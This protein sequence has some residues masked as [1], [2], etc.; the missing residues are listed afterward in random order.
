ML[1]WRREARTRFYTSVLP[2][3]IV[4]AQPDVNFDQPIVSE[5]Q[6]REM[7]LEAMRDFERDQD[8]RLI[9][10]I[11]DEI[12]DDA[13]AVVTEWEQKTCPDLPAECTEALVANVAFAIQAAV[14][15]AADNPGAF[16]CNFAGDGRPE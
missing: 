2:K 16:A 1:L 12:V 8:R 11:P 4:A 6:R 7:L 9:A 5:E 15:G 13:K 3:A 14:C 10:G